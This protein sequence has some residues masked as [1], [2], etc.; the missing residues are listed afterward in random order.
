MLALPSNATPLIVLA[1]ANFVAVLALPVNAAVIVP[2]LKLPVPSLATIVLT[3]FVVAES[4]PSS[5]SASNPEPVPSTVCN[6]VKISVPVLP[7]ITS[8]ISFLRS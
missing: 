8:P 6:L 3:I 5:K 7:A 4:L 1:V 2:A